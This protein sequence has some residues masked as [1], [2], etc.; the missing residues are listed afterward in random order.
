MAL[1]SFPPGHAQMLG[2]LGMHGTYTANIAMHEAELIINIGARFDDRVT[3]VVEH[4]ARKAQKIHVDVD[5]SSVNKSVKVDLIDEVRGP[6]MDA[7]YGMPLP[8][9]ATGKVQFWIQEW[10]RARRVL[11]EAAI[12]AILVYLIRAVGR[13]GQTFGSGRVTTLRRPVR[14]NIFSE[15]TACTPTNPTIWSGC[16]Q[17]WAEGFT[18]LRYKPQI[19]APTPGPIASA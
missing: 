9:F 17:A 1:G 12:R 14:P 7:E 19:T 2:M 18:R 3:G 8:G 13:R 11:G 16:P 6:R 15:W 4:F 10:R 5:P